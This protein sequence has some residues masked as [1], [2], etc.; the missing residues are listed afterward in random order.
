MVPGITISTRLWWVPE[1]RAASDALFDHT[2]RVLTRPWRARG[3]IDT[4]SRSERRRDRGDSAACASAPAAT[5]VSSRAADHAGPVGRRRDRD[6]DDCAAR[7]N[8]ASRTVAR[9]RGGPRAVE[10]DAR[11]PPRPR[12]RARSPRARE[13]SRARARAR[14]PGQHPPNANAVEDALEESGRLHRAR[15]PA[16]NAIEA[17]ASDHTIAARRRRAALGSRDDPAGRA[18]DRRGAASQSRRRRPSWRSRPIARAAASSASS[19]NT[20]PPASPAHG[21]KPRHEWRP[22]LPECAHPARR[23]RFRGEGIRR[24]D[25]ELGGP[26]R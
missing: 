18:Y 14:T 9:A 24:C 17:S 8:C 6:E 22:G 3:H 11:A 13:P 1:E 15:H 2:V 4:R 20:H 21:R 26:L 7:G 19:R 23:E 25:R 16:A 5:S 12:A 10:H